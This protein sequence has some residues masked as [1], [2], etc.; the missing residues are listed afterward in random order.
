[1]AA[2]W[3]RST[4]VLATV[5]QSL[6]ADPVGSSFCRGW[7]KK[8]WLCPWEK[9]DL[10]G[11]ILWDEQI[12]V[13]LLWSL[14]IFQIKYRHTK[15]VIIFKF[16]AKV[17]FIHACVFSWSAYFCPLTTPA[18]AVCFS[19]H[20]RCTQAF[21]CFRKNVFLFMFCRWISSRTSVISL[22]HSFTHGMFTSSTSPG[23]AAHHVKQHYVYSCLF[24]QVLT[25]IFILS[26]SG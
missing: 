5:S 25:Y 7:R 15:N 23:Q 24:S 19:V 4:F 11:W 9:V 21:V 10:C 26:G 12:I 17:H 13:T 16:T 3:Y 2:Q 6:H 22:S 1:M 18:S 20:I 14:K 8:R